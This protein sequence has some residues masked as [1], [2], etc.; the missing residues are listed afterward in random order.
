[1][2]D[3]GNFRDAIG[4]CWIIGRAYCPTCD[5]VR[6]FVAH[7]DI[8]QLRCDCGSVCEPAHSF[9]PEEARQRGRG[10]AGG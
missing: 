4:P 3:E 1:M 2:P 10:N 8:E 9:A 7:I 5:Q 6:A